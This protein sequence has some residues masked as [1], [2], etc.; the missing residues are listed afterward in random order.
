MVD[1]ATLHSVDHLSGDGKHGAMAKTSGHA[2]T[3]VDAGEMLILCIAAERQRFFDDWREILVI[4]DVDGV[5]IGDNFCGENA[6][7]VATARWHETVGGVK[8]RRWDA[9]KFLLLILP[10]GT[11]ISLEMWIFFKLWIS[12]GWQHFAVGV[13]IHALILCLLKQ[14]LEIVKIV[15]GDNDERPFFNGERNL[16]WFWC[17]VGFSVG[18]IEQRHAGEVDFANFEHDRQKLI[19]A[20][21]VVADGSEGFVEK[22]LHASV[23]IAENMRVISI[24]RHALD[25]EEDQRFQ[26]ANVLVAVPYLLHVV[27][28][29]LCAAELR[30]LGLDAIYD[31]L[32][33]VV[34][35]ADICDGGEKPVEN[36][37]VGGF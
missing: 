13:D 23:G 1:L 28:R 26:R 37:L 21:F 33:G 32:N 15:T 7:A 25:A 22:L 2:V 31:H 9:V 36:E 3:A 8:D 16:G 17:A 34:V 12:V 14:L 20:K 35:E 24:R 18:A 5:W 30:F 6:V 29:N 4:A 27:I 11:E 10:C 19:H